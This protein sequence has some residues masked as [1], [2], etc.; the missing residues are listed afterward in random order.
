MKLTRS[1]PVRRLRAFAGQVGLLAVLGLLAAAL[2]TGAPR[3][4]NEY[5]DRGL[6]ADVATLP[7]L[8]RDI[9][10][11]MVVEPDNTAQ[12][13]AG[14]E[15]LD[16]YRDRLPNPLP[17]LIED[18][19]YSATVGPNGVRA[20]GDFIPLNGDAKPG[21]GL[22]AQTGLQEAVRMVDGGW[23]AA[24]GRAP[25]GGIA[26][27]VSQLTADVLSLR[28]GSRFTVEGLGGKPTDVELVGIFEPLDPT[29]PIWNGMR[30][31]VEPLVPL[32]DGDPF[33]TMAVTN[34]AGMDLA[35]WNVGGLV[36]DWYYRVDEK[37]LDA[38]GIEPVITALTQLKQ[39][40]PVAESKAITS[41]DTALAKIGQRL[42]SVRALLAVVQTGVLAS[43]I[44]LIL[45]AARLSL[46][47]RREELALLRARGASTR[48]IGARVLAES[49]LVQPLAVLVGWLVGTLVPGRPAATEWL[50]P[51][52]AVITTGSVAVLAMSSQRQVTFVVRRQDLIRQRPS[53]RRLTAEISVL[54][55]AALGVFLLRRRGLASSGGVDP[56]LVS[57]PVLLAVG[58]ALIALR[59]LP[60]PLRMIGQVAT[61]ARGAVL[62]LG[63]A[64]AGRGAPVTIGPLAVLVVAITTGVFSGVVADTI[65]TARDEATDQVMPAD[66]TVTGVTF[67]PTT[68]DRISALPGVAAVVPVSLENSRQLRSGPGAG[69]RELGQAQVVVV[70]VPKFVEVM[71]RSGLPTDGVPAALR[72]ATRGDGPV[73]ALVS[74]AVAAQVGKGAVANVQG[75]QYAFTTSTVAPTFPGL[76]L[77]VER[78]V[79]LP[80]Q[81][82]PVPDFKPVLPN[83]FL[84]AGHGYDRTALLRTADDGQREWREGVTGKSAAGTTVPAELVTRTDYRRS[85]DQTGGNELL[86]LTFAIGAAGA[87]GLALLAVGFA[88]VAEARTRGKVLSRLRTMGLSGRQGRQL[89]VYEL[90]PLVG[91]AVVAGGVV[92]AVLPGLLGP[93]LNLST[94]TAGVAARTHLDPL[95]VG[96]VLLLVVVGLAAALAIENLINRRM[97]LGE[98]LRLGEEN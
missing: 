21:M 84:L 82:L 97:R 14:V 39:T 70:D 77:D 75:R 44:G 3:L 23:P 16:R 95:L 49:V 79:V 74:P 87:T 85:L 31:A 92:G 34:W 41:L 88:V 20:S 83:R 71:R 72:Q 17:G 40:P 33:N 1:G 37:R 96:G 60:W 38:G 19:W 46:E 69:D 65:S 18:G 9:S 53:A 94:F 81:A 89:L 63:L 6:A 58:T 98:V 59:V 32:L 30:L 90:L 15:T 55:V 50:V 51:V 67:A 27:T 61:R 22:R 2:L 93:A 7:P 25:G 4:A 54:A 57:V 86:S 8:V 62:F 29:A 52:L 47:R 42:A 91:A 28:V 45:L 64:R 5:A 66:A 10:M 24:T 73:P 26:I 78:F 43:L 13:S 12:A 76:E 56:Y 68:T 35:R 11:P 36:Y 80:W 48:T